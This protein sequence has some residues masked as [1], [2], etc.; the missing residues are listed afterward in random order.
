MISRRDDAD[1]PGR[2]VKEEQQRNQPV[3]SFLREAGVFLRPASLLV[4]HVPQGTHRSLRLASRRNTLR[5]IDAGAIPRPHKRKPKLIVIVGPTASGKSELAVKLDKTLRQS[6]G[7]GGEIISADSRQIYRGLDIGTGK[8]TGQWSPNFRSPTSDGSRTSESSEVFFYKKIPHYCIDFV[9]PRRTFTVAEYKKC[10]Q[11]AIRDITGR[12]KIPILVGGTG[13]WIDTVVYNFNLP[14]VPPNRGLRKKLERKEVPELLKMLQ[15]LDPARALSIEQKNPRRLI[16]AIEIAKALGHVPKLIKRSPYNILWIGLAP[17]YKVGLRKIKERTETMI[18]LGLIPET[19][20]LLQQG[21]SR[22]RIKEF[23]FEYR[24]ALDAADH[25]L[26]IKELREKLLS[27]TLQYARR[28][29]TWF[30]KNK[31]IH[32]ISSPFHLNGTNIRRTLA[33]FLAS[34]SHVSK[35]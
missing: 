10:A 32:W 20:K 5:S 7:R 6:S 19:K 11:K 18:K 4:A 26:P 1:V 28:Q 24:L 29:M 31:E 22:K 15:K 21:V 35:F 16:R 25:K 2:Y 14:A 9:S 27:E 34:R 33:R 8:V 30:K 17:S 12:G 3:F 13:F 23:G